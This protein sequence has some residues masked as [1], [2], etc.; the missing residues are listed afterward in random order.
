MN[1]A[2]LTRRLLLIAGFCIAGAS[3]SQHLNAQ[4]P[5]ARQIMQ[6]VD[7]QSAS[8]SMELKA[9]FEVF[10]HDGHSPKKQFILRHLMVGTVDKTLAVFTAPRRDSRSRSAL[11][12]GAGPGIAT[13]SVYARFAAGSQ[14]RGAREIEPVHRY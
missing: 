9:S 8:K 14:C 1:Q 2:F 6:Q 10:D 4:S 3:L 5:D 13:I 11:G 7:I 12:S